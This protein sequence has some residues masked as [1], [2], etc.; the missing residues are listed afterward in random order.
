VTP[1]SEFPATY[2][3]DPFSVNSDCHHE[4][5]ILP[6][7]TYAKADPNLTPFQKAHSV[8]KEPQSG[9]KMKRKVQ[10]EVP[11]PSGRADEHLREH[12]E[13]ITG[14]RL[15]PQSVVQMAIQARATGRSRRRGGVDTEFPEIQTS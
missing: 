15:K 9:K 1:S 12:R 2:R 8:E 3:T 4:K 7:C 10:P 14:T 5:F 13:A 11:S 6:V